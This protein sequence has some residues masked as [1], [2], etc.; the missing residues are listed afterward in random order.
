MLWM[1]EACKSSRQ[2]KHSEK[3]TSELGYHTE[4]PQTREKSLIWKMRSL[5]KWKKKALYTFA[6]FLLFPRCSLLKPY[7]F[8]LWS[9]LLSPYSVGLG[10]LGEECSWVCA[11]HFLQQQ[12]PSNSLSMSTPSQVANRGWEY[13]SILLS[14]A[15]LPARWR[16]SASTAIT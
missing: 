13:S 9:A 11:Q 16:G 3:K 8:S 12:Q 5:C 14:W 6:Q 1:Q 2:D 7:S 10:L 4:K 15:V